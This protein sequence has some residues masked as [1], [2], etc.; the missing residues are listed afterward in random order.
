M[1]SGPAVQLGVKHLRVSENLVGTRVGRILRVAVGRD[2][3]ASLLHGQRLVKFVSL[4]EHA[5][6]A[7]EGYRDEDLL[8]RVVRVF[9]RRRQKS[10]DEN[11]DRR[12]KTAQK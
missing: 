6:D 2:V 11:R 8:L 4:R 5:C 9:R 1:S 10:R 3:Q 7:L 12:H